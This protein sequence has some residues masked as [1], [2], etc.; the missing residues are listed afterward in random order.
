MHEAVEIKNLAAVALLLKDGPKE[1]LHEPCCGILPLSRALKN[2]AQRADQSYLAAEM[3][4][5]HGA[6]PDLGS[7]S[8][9]DTPLHQAAAAGAIHAVSLLLEH[10]A[11]PNERNSEGFTPLHSLCHASTYL[12]RVSKEQ[13]VV[14]LLQKGAE[15]TLT[16]QS[17]HLAVDYLHS[18]AGPYLVMHQPNH[19][20]NEMNNRIRERLLR[21]AFLYVR[22]QL[23]LASGRC[24]NESGFS[25]LPLPVLETVAHFM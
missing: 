8:N 9:C 13:V 22:L 24:E 4:L 10:G 7:G 14:A 5:K 25:K 17:G 23:V 16:D 19:V 3:L 6:N 1:L 20:H 18:P 2:A 21:A 15:P 11:N 12:P